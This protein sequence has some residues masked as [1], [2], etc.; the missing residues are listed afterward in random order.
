LGTINELW[1]VRSSQFPCRPEPQARE[2][3]AEN[4]FSLACGSGFDESIV[5]FG[6]VTV[7]CRGFYR[8]ARS[9][10]SAQGLYS[11]EHVVR[12]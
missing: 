4:P 11:W 12:S 2:T 9:Y 8:S 6:V 1:N 5:Q 10:L 7:V 3:V